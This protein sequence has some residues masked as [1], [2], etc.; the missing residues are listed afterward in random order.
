MGT[1]WGGLEQGIFSFFHWA[2]GEDGETVVIVFVV[3][4]LGRDGQ[5]RFPWEGV[6]MLGGSDGSVHPSEPRGKSWSQTPATK[7][8]VWEMWLRQ[9]YSC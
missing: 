9:K 6:V 1:V 3:V 2:G 5:R 7:P 4:L 8:A